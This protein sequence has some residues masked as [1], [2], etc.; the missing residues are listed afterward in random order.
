M[1]VPVAACATSIAGTAV[2]PVVE[3]RG[4]SGPV[5]DGLAKFYGQALNWEDC[6]PYA[7]SAADR[8]VMSEDTVRCTRLTVPLDY[9]KPDGDTITIGVLRTG[10]ERHGGRRPAVRPGAGR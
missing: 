10:R 7:R 5:P 6:A 1:L 8:S 4:P 2:A 9:T 3:R